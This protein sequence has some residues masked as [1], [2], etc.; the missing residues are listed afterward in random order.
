MTYYILIAAVL[1]LAGIFSSK[2][3][4]RFGI[5][6]LVLFLGIGMLAGSDGPGGIYFNNADLAKFVGT[7][8]L[9]YILFSGAMETDFKSIR[10]I[11]GRGIVL[12]TIG[13][14][15]TAALTAAFTCIALGFSIEEGMMIGAIVSSTDAA[16][17]FAILRSKNMGLTGHLRPLLELESGSNDP[18]AI[19]LTVALISFFG[20]SHSTIP[21]MLWQFVVSMSVGAASGIVLGKLA[22]RVL[23]KVGLDYEGLYP[24][25]SLAI[26]LL[27][28]SF[29][30]AI[31][32]NG[33]V[34]IYLCGIIMGNSDFP[35]KRSLI[36]FHNGLAWLMQITMFVILGLLVFPSQL[37]SVTYYGLA[38]SAFMIIIA[39][40]ATIYL[41]MIKSHFSFREKTLI[42]WAGL[43]GAV[44]I[45][46][47]TFPLM[48][49]YKG[50]DRI[51]NIVFFIVLTSVMLQGKM[52]LPVAKWLKVHRNLDSR[53]RYPLEFDK[54]DGT[55][56]QTRE[57][58]IMPGTAAV[59]KT[60]SQLQLPK[61]A[62]ILLIRR[63]N[64]F[65]VPKGNTKLEPFDTLMVMGKAGDLATTWETIRTPAPD[66][67]LEHN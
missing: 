13:V 31:K 35:Y 16:A 63:E 3:S 26:G 66:D 45:V 61:N 38:I 41:C 49:G 15:L 51:F 30:E 7:I 17:V 1:L 21:D 12:A 54:T 40:P 22:V 11:M 14:F 24:V 55:D 8:A 33:Y 39:R 47:A 9:I 48:A 27:V 29:T 5:P 20:Q 67:R 56:N 18:M 37:P 62:L 50:S 36:R 43:R 10:P 64:T 65:V 58:E 60:I 44:P 2:I 4:E 59:G 32:G 53:P 23:N 25:L 6:A 28:Y 57:Y 19:F 42:A 46:L 52:L 34:A